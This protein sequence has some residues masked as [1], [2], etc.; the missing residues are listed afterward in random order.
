MKKNL[1]I[2]AVAIVLFSCKNTN[3]ETSTE[4]IAPAATDSIPVV[5][6]DEVVNTVTESQNEGSVANTESADVVV[7]KPQQSSDKVSYV[8][9]GKKITADNVLSP[10]Q[11]L[12]KYKNLKTGDT[13]S[14]KF[15]SS[16]KEVCK[17]KGC[18]MS[19]AMPG[20]EAFVRFKDYGFFVPL[21]ADGSEAIVGGRA[22]VDV[23]SV[24][25]LQHYAKDG[26]KSQEEINKITEPK[27]T[28]AFQADGVLIKE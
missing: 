17:K 22:Y 2:V 21:N 20:E 16:I 5:G 8:T 1:L 18:W 28:Y 13:I 19:M 3:S 12:T 25:Q 11:M 7:E 15:K 14:V 26:G 27:V 6:R 24:S 23:I 4:T 10:A 9:F